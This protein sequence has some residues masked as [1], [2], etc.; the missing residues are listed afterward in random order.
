[1]ACL[2]HYQG[3]GPVTLESLRFSG[4]VALPHHIPPNVAGYAMG[5]TWYCQRPDPECYPA[6]SHAG[7]PFALYTWNLYQGAE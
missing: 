6:L 2:A 3:R 5:M 1:M 7:I 4:Y